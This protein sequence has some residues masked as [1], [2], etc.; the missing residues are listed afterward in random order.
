MILTDSDGAVFSAGNN[1]VGQLGCSNGDRSKFQ[2]IS[3]IPP[4]LAVSCGHWHTLALDQF[5]GVWVWGYASF[6]QLGSLGGVWVVGY[7]SLGQRSVGNL[8]RP[9]FRLKK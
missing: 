8:P 6:G 9:T 1:T 2:R 4:M 7:G 5:G 3:N